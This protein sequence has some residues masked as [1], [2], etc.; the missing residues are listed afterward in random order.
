MNKTNIS[1]QGMHC[2]SCEILIEDELKKI[3]GVTKVQIS[4]KTGVAELSYEKTAIPFSSLKQAVENA[5]YKIGE[6][7]KLTFFSQNK[8]DYVE[9]ITSF[10]ITGLI[11]LIGKELGLFQLSSSI[12]SEYNNLIVVLLIGLTAGVST[13]M[14]LI[15]GLILGV[16]SRYN[17]AHQHISTS[18]KFIPHILFNTGRI[19]GFFVLG[20][21][22][23]KMGS[24]FQISSGLIGGFTVLIGIVM[25]FL[26]LQLIG[27]FPLLSSFSL[28]LPK[29]ISRFLG[30]THQAEN[31][32]SP[33]NT[34]VLG[35]LTFFLPCGFTQAMQ[36]F[37]ISS[38]SFLKGALIMS[39][40]AVGTAPGL[41]GVGGLSS[42]LKG[43]I[44]RFFFKGAGIVVIALAIFNFLNGMNLLRASG[45]SIQ[46]P[47]AVN[48]DQDPNVVM[49][50]G[51]QIVKM[52]QNATGYVP[53]T[54]VIKKG[55]PVKWIIKS[56]ETRSCASSFIVPKL[57]IRTQLTEKEQIFEFTPKDEGEIPFSCSMGMYTGVFNVVN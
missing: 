51:I 42:V 1:I 37:A 17:Q 56:E 34:I 18:A 43:P 22:I 6:N 25:V 5:G 36:L 9:F 55:I 32:Y 57:N 7:N 29:G 31:S 48:R 8:Q 21:I 3:K 38:G 46:S 15:G 50:K 24:I 41:L 4:H 2:K 45:I 49:D 20:G 39:V 12:Q 13:C 44:S 16:S 28:T 26:G 23:G 11:F 52:I 35:A 53:N 10:L 19:I 33:R 27:I 30:L 47:A 54:I 40:F 14:A